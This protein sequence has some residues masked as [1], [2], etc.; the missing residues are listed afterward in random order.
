MQYNGS[1]NSIYNIAAL[2]ISGRYS[3]IF[4]Q[5]MILVEPGKYSLLA[6]AASKSKIPLNL[7][8]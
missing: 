3:A 1:Y 5:G 6:I 4:S 7:K 2:L 8:L